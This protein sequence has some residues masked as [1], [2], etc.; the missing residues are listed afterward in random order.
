MTTAQLLQ[1]VAPSVV[2]ATSLEQS[3]IVQLASGDKVDVAITQGC[4]F[5]GYNQVAFYGFLLAPT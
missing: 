3:A 4:Y 1:T 5:T 2:S